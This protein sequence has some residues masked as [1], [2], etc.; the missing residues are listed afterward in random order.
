M[1]NNVLLPIVNGIADALREINQ[2]AQIYIDTPPN[3]DSAT[4]GYFYIK[5]VALTNEKLLADAVLL[6]VT[7][8][9]MYFPNDL[10]ASNSVT[11]MDALYGLNFALQRIIPACNVNGQYEKKR[12]KKGQ[13]IES[14]IVDDVA[15]VLTRYDLHLDTEEK[16]ELVKDVFFIN[17]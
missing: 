11:L 17:E 15:H 2:S 8:D 14:K 3:V 10:H 9:I 1:T 7:F 6:H 12:P 4:G 16:T 13:S 5:P